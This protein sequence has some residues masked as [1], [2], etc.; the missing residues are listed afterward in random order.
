MFQVSKDS[1]VIDPGIYRSFGHVQMMM[2]RAASYIAGGGSSAGQKEARDALGT[3]NTLIVGLL[4]SNQ[5]ANGSSGGAMSQLMQQLQQMSQQQSQLNQMT[6]EL[7]Q[8]MEELGMSPGFERQLTDMRAQQEQILEQARRLAKEFGDR[9][10]IL[11]RLDD[12][13]GQMEQTLAEM[14]RSGASQETIDRQKRILSR[15]LDAQTSLRRRDYTR[16]RASTVG[17][18]YV[19]TGPGG[20]PED[21]ARATQE[22]REDLL[23]AMQRGYPS[24]YRPLIRAYFEDLTG[25]AATSRDG[26]QGRPDEAP[27]TP[28]AQGSPGG[29]GAPGSPGGGQR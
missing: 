20:L 26:T 1:Y 16:Q 17:G 7:R 13:V 19:R 21:V 12:T 6:E 18:E 22:L 3:V 27:R 5:S 23:R 24:E 28:G 14:E 8:R 25:D 4:T 9:R 11:G 10:E 29:P 15:L 2:T